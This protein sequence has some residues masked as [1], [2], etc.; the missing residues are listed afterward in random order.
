MKPQRVTIF[1]FIIAGVAIGLAVLLH[2]QAQSGEWTLHQS[3]EPGL[4]ELSITDAHGG[5]HFHSTSGW[6]VKEM[7]GLDLSKQGALS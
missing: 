1:T 4:V 2:A 7:T 3:N 5:H 6:Q